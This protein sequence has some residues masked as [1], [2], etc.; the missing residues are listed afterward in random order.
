MSCSTTASMARPSTTYC[1][2]A[3][4]Q[5]STVCPWQQRRRLS[6]LCG[7]SWNVPE[8]S[9]PKKRKGVTV[10]PPWQLLEEQM[11]ESSVV[12]RQVA[13]A[14]LGA[15]GQD[16]KEQHCCTT[17]VTSSWAVYNLCLASRTLSHSPEFSPGLNL[18]AAVYI[19]N[20]YSCK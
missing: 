19:F 11:S 4:S 10:E 3:T 12:A 1:T 2:R 16:G 7:N 18:Q 17:A 8:K 13:Q 6:Q 5:T 15:A 9:G 14:S 20:V